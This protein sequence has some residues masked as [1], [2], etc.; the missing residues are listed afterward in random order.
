MRGSIQ[1]D[2][3]RDDAEAVRDSIADVLCWIDGF[4]NGSGKSTPISREPLRMM[5]ACL[6]ARLNDE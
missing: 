3:T 2:I 1:I 4:E 6:K 5:Q